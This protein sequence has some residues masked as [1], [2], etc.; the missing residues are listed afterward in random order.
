MPETERRTEIMQRLREKA[1]ALPL[2]PGVY[3]MK[4]RKGE[5]IYVGKAVRLKN[6]VSSYFHGAHNAKTEAMVSKVED[7]DVIVASSEFEALV[8]ENSLIKHHMPH[9]NILLKDDKGYPFIRVDMREDYPSFSVVNRVGED[10]ADYY[11]PYGGRGTTFRAIDAVSKAL[12]LPT[13]GRKFPRDIG[14]SRPCLNYHMGACRGYCREGSSREEY[15][16]GMEAAIRLLSGKTEELVKELT[17][18]MERDAEGLRFEMA[19]EKR[20][21]IRAVTALKA[22]QR[23]VAGGFADT[24]AVGLHLGTAKSC[25]AVLHYIGGDLLDKD[26]EIIPTPLEDRP[27]ALA[28]MLA[29]YYQRRG[30]VPRSILLPCRPAGMEALEQLLNGIGKTKL[31]VPQKGE[32]ARLTE[33]ADVNAAEEA[34]RVSTRE[35]KQLKVLEWLRNAL[36]LKELPERIEAFDISNTGGDNIVAGMTVFVHARPKKGEYRRFRMKTVSGQD[37]YGSMRE[38]VG[39]RFR[40][41]LDGDE[42]FGTLPDLL[43]IDGGAAH[44][45]TAAAVLADLKVDIPV[46]GMVKDD[47]HRTRALAAPDGGEIGISANPGVFSFIGTI[48]E[49]THRCAIEYQRALQRGGTSYSELDGIRGVGQKRKQALLKAFGSLKAIA[50]A[51]REKLG[52][53]VDKRTAEAVYYH[54]HGE[55]EGKVG[56]KDS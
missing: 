5:V 28:A 37:D 26:Y 45:A 21:R 35:E 14:K 16:A 7:F 43:L 18:Q 19:A 36:H 34:E 4:D 39:R 11:G 17:E 32:R 29:G 6:R 48:Q 42:R 31:S 55:N 56:E 44:A 25:F 49:E 9:Y 54:F 51:D 27:D 1:A 30:S 33:T 10:G 13:C 52:K 22:T 15:R 23:V 46:F 8:L 3:L 12:K 47:R 53:V 2:K 20:D 38:A 50:A 40:R 41:Y 24:D